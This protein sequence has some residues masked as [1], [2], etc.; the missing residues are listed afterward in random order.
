M[1][2]DPENLPPPP[3]V[4]ELPEGKT[5]W[6]DVWSG[7]QG[8]GL[9]D[10]IPAVAELVRRLQGEY[11]AACGIP[12]MAEP[13]RSA[14]RKCEADNERQPCAPRIERALHA[15]AQDRKRVV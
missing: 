2:L 9:I 15:D 13:A 14:L 10:D 12:D 1:G 5:P 4:S 6:R 7:G 3:G 11:L 8:V